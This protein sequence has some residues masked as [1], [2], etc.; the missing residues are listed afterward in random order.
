MV[1][2][3]FFVALQ[4]FDMRFL[5]SVGFSALPLSIVF[6]GNV[7]SAQESD[8]LVIDLGYSKY[9]GFYN[10]TR[11]VTSYYGVRYAAPPTGA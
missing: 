6:L 11:D 7:A 2:S 3:P 5:T 8:L 1:V 10:S 4:L 9:Q